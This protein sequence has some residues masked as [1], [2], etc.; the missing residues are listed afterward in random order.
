MMKRP[1]QGA[2]RVAWLF[3]VFERV[4]PILAEQDSEFAKLVE[5]NQLLTDVIR[6]EVEQPGTLLAIAPPNIEPTSAADMMLMAFSVLLAKA[7]AVRDAIG[8]Q[9]VYDDLNAAFAPEAMPRGWG[10]WLGGPAPKEQKGEA[11][12]APEGNAE[13]MYHR[14]YERRRLAK[15]GRTPEQVEQEVR[16]ESGVQN[17]MRNAGIGL[18]QASH[19]DSETVDRTPGPPMGYREMH[20]D[21]AGIIEAAGLGLFQS[22][23]IVAEEKD[24][25]G[26]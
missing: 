14:E 3:Y 23:V 8:T 2:P 19:F 20:S 9:R 13:P 16:R 15:T 4:A 7:Q 17:I 10:W 1:E 12:F 24:D 21:S 11:Y 5:Q 22:N 26:T 6:Q 18:F 25:E